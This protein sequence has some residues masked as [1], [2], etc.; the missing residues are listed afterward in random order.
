M[1]P[2]VNHFNQNDPGFRRAPRQRLDVWTIACCVRHALGCDGRV[3][4][5]CDVVCVAGAP[6]CI[7]GTFFFAYGGILGHSDV[8]I[9]PPVVSAEWGKKKLF[10]SKFRL[11]S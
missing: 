8:L 10:H 2:T 11:G 5:L 7:R 9:G 1:Q 3:C 6:M 4:G